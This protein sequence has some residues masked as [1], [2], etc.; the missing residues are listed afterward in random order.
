MLKGPLWELAEAAARV[1]VERWHALGYWRIDTD[2]TSGGAPMIFGPN[3]EKLILADKLMLHTTL[4]P[5]LIE[6]KYKNHTDIYQKGSVKSL[7]MDGRLRQWQHGFDL[8]KWEHYLRAWEHFGI[9]VLVAIVVLKPGVNADPLPHLLWET[10]DVLKQHVQI[11]REAHTTFHRGAAY[12][13]MPAW[14]CIPID[15]VPPQNLPPIFHNI[16][17][18]EQKAKSGIAPAWKIEFSLESP[19]ERPGCACGVTAEF[20]YCS[21]GRLIWRCVKH[22]AKN[23][24]PDICFPV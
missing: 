16:N 15:F 21:Q 7:S 18:W 6:C 11:C 9:P 20:G 17:P 14:K 4:P 19:F 23:R 10:V 8:Y 22:Q 5:L 2:R 12:F 13:P 24:P 3:G 1:A